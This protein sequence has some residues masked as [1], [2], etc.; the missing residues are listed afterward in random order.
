MSHFSDLMSPSVDNRHSLDVHFQ[1]KWGARVILKPS[2][3]SQ[4]GIILVSN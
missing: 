3:G 2:L 1:P 4:W